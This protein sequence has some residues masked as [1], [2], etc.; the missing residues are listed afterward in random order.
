MVNRIIVAVACLMTAWAGWGDCV[1]TQLPPGGD[2]VR[3]VAIALKEAA[4]F[5]ALQFK[6]V[7]DPARLTLRKIEVNPALDGV[8]RAI[9]DRKPGEI[10][11]AFASDRPIGATDPVLTL[12]MQ[13]E[14]QVRVEQ[15]LADDRPVAPAAQPIN[16]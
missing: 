5:A 12:E 2:G 10:R 9:N 11:V 15:I 1:I 6:V 3:P 16:K 14:G 4:P 8:A 7:Y 13:G